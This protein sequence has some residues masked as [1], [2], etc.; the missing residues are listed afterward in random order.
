MI[1]YISDLH[2]KKG[3]KRIINDRK[4]YLLL[5]GDFGYQRKDN[6]KDFML[7][8]TSK[9]DKVFIVAG[10]HEYDNYNVNDFFK[11]EDLIKNICSMRNNLF[12]LQKEVHL[13]S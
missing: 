3:C 8:A 9:F 12:F 7:G 1:Q 5:C 6:Y 13:I 10:N 4:P 2:L 11:V